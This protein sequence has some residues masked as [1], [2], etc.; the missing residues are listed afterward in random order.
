VLNPIG[1][2]YAH[3]VMGEDGFV[4]GLLGGGQPLFASDWAGKIGVS[5]AP[6]ADGGW[7]EWGRRVRVDMPV[8]QRYAESV[9]SST[10]NYIATLRDG[11]LDRSVDLSSL[12]FGQQS[13]AWVLG[14]G[15]LGHVLSH[16]GEICA[17]NGLRGRQGFPR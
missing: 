12:G 4:N 2:T 8:L 6:P 11:E 9:A 16:W 1:A 3:L 14:A 13:L 10:D 7:H 17:L 15:V 5:E